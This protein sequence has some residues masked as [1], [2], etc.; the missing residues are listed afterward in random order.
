MGQPGRRIDLRQ[1]MPET[2]AYV[3]RRRAEWGA[4]YVNDKI[5]RAVKDGEANCFYAVEGGHV[6]GTPFQ[7]AVSADVAQLIL[8]W[9]MS[10]VCFLQAPEREGSDGAPGVG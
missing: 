9:G 1:Q 2:A 5:K 10:F 3:D 4:D 8:H 7:S 6:L